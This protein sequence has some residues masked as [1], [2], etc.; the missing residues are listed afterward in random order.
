MPFGGIQ[1]RGTLESEALAYLHT[2]GI[3]VGGWSYKTTVGF[4]YDI[5]KYGCGILGQKGFFNVFEVKFDLLK[6]Q[7]E[8]KFRLN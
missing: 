7:I 1:K 6:E 5:A 8:L 4:S 3:E 2:V